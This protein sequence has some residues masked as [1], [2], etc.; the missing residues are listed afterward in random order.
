LDTTR[1]VLGHADILVDLVGGPPEV[2]ADKEAVHERR[3]RGGPVRRPRRPETY[4]LGVVLLA[5]EGSAEARLLLLYDYRVNTKLYP[6][7]K[8]ASARVA[9]QCLLPLSSDTND[10]VLDFVDLR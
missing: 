3:V 7:G 1:D 5:R 10:F 6:H 4:T 2:R 8:S 9:C